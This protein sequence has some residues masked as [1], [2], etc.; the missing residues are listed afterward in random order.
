MLF[1][2]KTTGLKLWLTAPLYIYWVQ[3]HFSD[4]QHI[5]DTQLQRSD[6]QSKQ[7]WIKN[8]LLLPPEAQRNVQEQQQPK[9][10]L[11]FSLTLLN[12]VFH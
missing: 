12:T 11:I 9:L 8:H 3:S 7:G 2:F 5:Q 10:V 6:N 1:Q 4:C